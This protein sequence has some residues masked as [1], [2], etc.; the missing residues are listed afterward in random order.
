MANDILRAFAGELL[1]FRKSS[2][3]QLTQAEENRLAN[4]QGQDNVTVFAP[5]GEKTIPPTEADENFY[6]LLK[7]SSDQVTTA[8]PF[9]TFIPVD[10][11]GS[12]VSWKV[13]KPTSPMALQ[14]LST[15]TE[16]EQQEITKRP[17]VILTAGQVIPGN[18]VYADLWATIG[19][20]R[21]DKK[22]I[23][24]TRL[25]SA[26][27]IDLSK[28][29]Q[30][31]TISYGFEGQIIPV[32]SNEMTANI[33]TQG[34][35]GWIK[36]TNLLGEDTVDEYQLAIALNEIRLRNP[37]WQVYWERIQARQKLGVLVNTIGSPDL[38]VTALEIFLDT[39]SSN[40]N[41]AKAAMRAIG[42]SLRQEQNLDWPKMAEIINNELGKQPLPIT[43]NVG[44]NPILDFMKATTGVS[45]SDGTHAHKAF[46]QIFQVAEGEDYNMLIQADAQ[47]LLLLDPGIL[48]TMIE[49]IQLKW[50]PLLNRI[51]KLYV[52]SGEAVLNVQAIAWE[53][54]RDGAVELAK[55]ILSRRTAIVNAVRRTGRE[56]GTQ[57]ANN[58][59]EIASGIIREQ[60]ANRF[61]NATKQLPGERDGTAITVQPNK[62]VGRG[63]SRSRHSFPTPSARQQP[64]EPTID[65]DLN[66]YSPAE[67][68]SNRLGEA[69][70]T[71][72]HVESITPSSSAEPEIVD[73]SLE[74]SK[75]EEPTTSLNDLPPAE[76]SSEPRND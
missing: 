8:L 29:Q 21:P 68:R 41:K 33:F 17:M 56:T 19:Q 10:Y 49:G 75:P 23:Q 2:K 66:D 14:G 26:L 27:A 18:D 43:L 44:L 37:L 64:K 46:E 9:H 63:V 16:Q 62:N 35:M 69:W 74:P 5:L 65:I 70:V 47:R 34:L 13:P 36:E 4:N 51:T 15:K 1:E 59:A 40:F 48:T 53:A 3:E 73:I 32:F 20:W 30:V 57:I 11:Q 38:L 72:P 6:N 24:I 52:E 31:T 67:G 45:I 76:G 58:L 28:R 12:G 42:T 7:L 50:V 54:Y 71:D 25:S 55:T 39:S 22:R 60:I 61:I